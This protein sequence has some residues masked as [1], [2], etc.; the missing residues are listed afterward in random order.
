MKKLILI[1]IIFILNL[2]L[3]SSISTDNLLGFYRF[4]EGSG[5]IALDSS[6]N[7]NDLDIVGATYND[8]FAGSNATGDF[9]LVFDG[10][11]YITGGNIFNIGGVTANAT[12][13]AWFNTTSTARQSIVSK[14][15]TSASQQGFILGTENGNVFVE[16]R[17]RTANR[18]DVSTVP[19][20]NDGQWH[21][22][23]ITYNG[24]TQASGVQIFIDTVLQNITVTTDTL[25]DS[26]E[27]TQEFNIGAS[28]DGD[29]EHF[30]GQID[31]VALFNVVLNFT[32][33]LEVENG[34]LAKIFKLPAIIDR[35][36]FD[37]TVCSTDISDAMLLSF[38]IILSL[39]FILIGFL[40]IMN[41]V[42]LFGSMMLFISSWFIAPCI[43]IFATAITLLSML[44]FIHFVI[45]GYKR[46]E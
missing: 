15:T 4:E 5:I 45:R 30:T 17:A 43:N 19:T 39:I 21:H 42:G 16:L 12:L 27:N 8:S 10:T 26:F 7:N 31:E 32:E 38:F 9:S 23:L 41:F 18:I 40:F 20:Y 2:L 1:P 13:T 24:T 28:N 22:V 29:A 14:K 11:N 25:T 46:E 3:V 6:S 44:L 35:Q 36:K 37:V 33:I 34:T